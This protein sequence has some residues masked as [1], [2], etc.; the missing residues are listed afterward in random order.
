ML[1]SVK[2]D[3]EEYYGW[4]K[5]ISTTWIYS[6]NKLKRKLFWL[7]MTWLFFV[8]FAAVGLILTLTVVG[9]VIGIP[10]LIGNGVFMAAITQAGI[11][12][13]QN[14]DDEDVAIIYTCINC[15]TPVEKENTMCKNCKRKRQPEDPY[16]NWPFNPFAG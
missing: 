12:T 10:L 11:E 15:G 1:K 8:P 4:M 3:T 13:R 2:M 14:L 16:A 5:G 6:K 9:A 7:M